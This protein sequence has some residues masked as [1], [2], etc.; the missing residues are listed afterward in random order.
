MDANPLEA[1]RR[2][3]SRF[4]DFTR[5]REKKTWQIICH[6]I[7]TAAP[8]IPLSS[9]HLQ[10]S[11][12]VNTLHA[13]P[14]PPTQLSPHDAAGRDPSPVPAPPALPSP[15]PPGSCPSRRP[16]PPVGLRHR[17]SRRPAFPCADASAPPA[18]ERRE[19]T[20]TVVPCPPSCACHRHRYYR[21]PD[22]AAAADYS[23]CF[24]APSPPRARQT[25]EKTEDAGRAYRRSSF[26]RRG[27]S[28]AAAAA[29]RGGG[30]VGGPQPKEAVR[31]AAP[32][33]RRRESLGDLLL[34]K[35]CIQTHKR[36]A[37]RETSPQ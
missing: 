36:V 3:I 30:G 23:R 24:F 28:A 22:V 31:P 8:P 33:P 17:P 34:L 1:T 14:L 19:A 10:P 12:V 11:P 29:A 5:C 13:P 6:L 37:V 15:P 20:K 4:H 21:H 27:P 7:I 16:S 32:A 9:P 2:R 35:L 25:K 26:R 18:A